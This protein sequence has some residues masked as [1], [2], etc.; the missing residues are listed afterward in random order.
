MPRSVAARFLVLTSS[1]L[2]LAA[3]AAGC[4]APPPPTP[5]TTPCGGFPC[6]DSGRPLPI[7]A[8]VPPVPPPDLCFAADFG[9]PCERSCTTP[10]MS[11]FAE[12]RA[13]ST[14]ETDEG[15]V[16]LDAVAFPDGLCSVACSGDSDCG[17]CAR[18]VPYVLAGRARLRGLV[19]AP[20]VCRP[21][22]DFGCATGTVC[23]PA[24]GACVEACTDDAQCRFLT[25]D[26]DGDGV[27]DA[28]AY[29]ADAELICLEGRCRSPVSAIGERCFDDLSCEPG[30]ACL[31]DPG[32]SSAGRC[33]RSGCSPGTCGEGAACVRRDDGVRVCAI[34]CEIGADAPEDRVGPR[35]HGPGC[36]EG[37]ACVWTGVARAAGEPPEGACVPGRYSAVESA[38]VGAPCTADA[39]CWSPFGRGA[40]FLATAGASTGVCAVRDCDP[41][42]NGLRP[43][44][45]VDP[46]VCDPTLGQQ[47][48]AL[49][50]GDTVCAQIC[51]AAEDCLTGWACVLPTSGTLDSPR[52]CAPDCRA[53]GDCRAGGRC[54]APDASPCTASDVGCVC[55]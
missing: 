28:L 2:A 21:R 32:S 49:A 4:C 40:C 39:D 7:D 25:V 42:T 6:T 8:G 26:S 5:P 22:C 52:V 45:V 11:C 17:S 51:G 54:L 19:G 50:A 31:R 15:P 27:E 46:P 34:A 35:G 37:A 12:R 44:V 9:A 38:N 14:L 36:D 48:F 43:G 33:G 1:L 47:C 23:D 18:C 3:L 20:G 30:F 29:E 55:R 10:G 13:R 53:D 41:G 24:L 16:T